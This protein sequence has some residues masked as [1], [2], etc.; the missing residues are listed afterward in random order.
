MTDNPNTMIL[1]DDRA[2][3]ERA[4]HVIETLRTR[5]VADGF[6]LDEAGARRTLKYFR[7]CADGRWDW[8]HDEVEEAQ[9]A[10]YEA[11]VTWLYDHGQSLDW[12]LR[13]EPPPIPPS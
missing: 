10:E 2:A 9:Q 7:D 8:R 12:V 4:E 11:A 3:L 5:H 13:G 1:R 6:Q